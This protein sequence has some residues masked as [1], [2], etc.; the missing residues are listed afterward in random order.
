MPIEAPM[1]PIGLPSNGCSGGGR[2]VH[3]VLEHGGN[4]V[5]VFRGDEK[6]SVRRLDAG[7]KILDWLR[8]ALLPDIFVIQ[9]NGCD[10]EAVDAHPL[11]RQFLG[12]AQRG[13]IER[14]LAQVAGDPEDAD[15][16]ASAH[17]TNLLDTQGGKD[18]RRR[19]KMPAP[20]GL[21]G[22]AALE[23]VPQRQFSAPVQSTGRPPSEPTELTLQYRCSNDTWKRRRAMLRAG[24]AYQSKA[25]LVRC[26]RH[27]VS[28]RRESGKIIRCL[29]DDIP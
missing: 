20:A 8:K 21:A 22:S 26:H 27:R 2:P 10:I 3:G 14:A 25:L 24:P 18:E 29:K 7:A 11:G 4:G 17:D 15:R 9:R 19:R 16:T 23:F 13:T 1:M 28:V 6:Q 5:V 12:H